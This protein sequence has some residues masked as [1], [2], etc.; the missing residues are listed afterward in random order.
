MCPEQMVPGDRSDMGIAA[1]EI[2]IRLDSVHSFELGFGVH[3][4]VFGFDGV[5]SD[6]PS[7]S[8]EVR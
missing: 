4:I 6:I 2:T 8:I 7:C 1:V 5:M 3:V